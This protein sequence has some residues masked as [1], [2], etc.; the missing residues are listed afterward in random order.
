[1]TL[2]PSRPAHELIGAFESTFQ[3]CYDVDVL[4]SSGH[5]RRRRGDLEALRELGVRRL[6]YPVRWHRV[7]QTPGVYDW[8]EVDAAMAELAELGMSPIV[9]L[10][11]HTSYPTW[12]THS[13][14]DKRFGPAYLAY[15]EAF[16][17]RYPQTV[18][19]TL[20]N[21]PFATL[22]LAGHEALWPPYGHGNAAF[23][24]VLREVVPAIAAA[25]RMAAELL[26]NA[27]HVWVDS[28]EYHSS[29]PGRGEAYAAICNDR[30]TCVLDLFL[31]HDLDPTRPYLRELL[32]AGGEDLFDIT[33]GRIDV[34]GLDYYAHSEWWYAA[35]GAGCA[36][37]PQPIGFAALAQQY[38]DRYG[39]PMILGE[40]NVRGF[41]SDRATWM[42]YMAEEYE[43]AVAAGV[44]LQGFCWFPVIDSRDWDSLL[45]RHAKRRDPVGIFEPFAAQTSVTKSYSLLASGATAAELPAY[46]LQ[47]PAA[48]RLGAFLSS[49]DDLWDWQDPP[50]HEVV[51]PIR[52][53]SAPAE[54]RRAS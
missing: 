51:P 43:T 10:V 19:Y 40:T 30:R 34:L 37:S 45:A 35:D 48:E 8:S 44:P 33:P 25:S 49:R 39:M 1:M 36:P 2:Q 20:F 16:C 17:R 52:L 46:R 14:A 50:A 27:K 26:P 9:D 18:E 24:R 3:P 28:C 31:G 12:L 53:E 54:Y 38:A 6:R 47:S 23:V 42:K 22:W 11:H 29:A 7:E 4:E 15:V 5:V 13:F 21:E 41:P 32:E